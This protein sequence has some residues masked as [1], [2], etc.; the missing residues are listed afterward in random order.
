LIEVLLHFES[1]EVLF[2]TIKF[3]IMKITVHKMKNRNDN[4]NS[5]LRN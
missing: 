1:L 2:G 3:Q 4:D 5:M